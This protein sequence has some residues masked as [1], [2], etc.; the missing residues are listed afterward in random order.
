M[1]VPDQRLAPHT[2]Y[3]TSF[4]NAPTLRSFGVSIFV[5]STVVTVLTLVEKLTTVESPPQKAI[6]LY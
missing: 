3:L 4:A 6:D 5:K 1:L 2:A